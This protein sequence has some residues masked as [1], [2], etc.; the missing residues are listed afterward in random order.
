MNKVIKR[1]FDIIFS[2]VGLI[3]SSPL[4]LMLAIAVKTTSKGTVI[5]KQERLGKNGNPFFM[6]KFRSMVENAEHMGTGL[7]NYE[8]DPRVTAIGRFMRDTSLD[9]LPQLVNVLKGD[10]SFV[11]PRPA[12]TY[13][14]GDYATLNKRYKKRFTVT[15]GITGLAQVCGRNNISWDDKV[16]YD[17]E[18]IDSFKKQGVI[19]DIYILFKTVVNVFCSKDIYEIPVD[20]VDYMT[21]AEEEEKE[22]IR[23]A[24][25]PEEGD[26]L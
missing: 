10:M 13:E 9:E 23:R 14:L 15:P 22:I 6:Y 16:N 17:N 4:F 24:H 25:A 21:S 7:F 12:V 5:F 2:L 20:D 8:N 3:I 11:G 1:F 18:Y 19:L 26:E